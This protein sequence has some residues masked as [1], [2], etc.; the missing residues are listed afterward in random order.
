MAAYGIRTRAP[1]KVLRKTMEGVEKLSKA[2]AI[3]KYGSPQNTPAR[4]NRTMP[5]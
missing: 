3:K 5:F 2:N 1:R 4:E